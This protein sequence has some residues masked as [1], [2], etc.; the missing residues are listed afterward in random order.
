MTDI[1][2]GLPLTVRFFAAAREAAG[3]ET[4]SLTLRPG[5]TVADA[6][7]ELCGQ[8]DQL[9]LV[10]QKCSYLCDGIA[11]RDHGTVL[12]PHQTLDILPPFAGG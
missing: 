11:V 4:A 2:T 1:T 10:L 3:S 9:A 7:R 6:I 12:R 8:S 5:A